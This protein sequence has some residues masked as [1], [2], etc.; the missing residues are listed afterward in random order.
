MSLSELAICKQRRQITD[1]LYLYRI[2]IHYIV[3]GLIKWVYSV[4][5]SRT[6]PTIRV[7][8]YERTGGMYVEYEKV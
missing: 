7:K 3:Q 8:Q 5:P 6:A 4:K 2:I 1:S